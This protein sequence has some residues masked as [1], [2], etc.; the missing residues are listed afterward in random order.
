MQIYGEEH[1]RWGNTLKDPRVGSVW[2]GVCFPMCDVSSVTPCGTADWVRG[3]EEGDKVGE[4]NRSRLVVGELWDM[5]HTIFDFEWD[6][7]KPMDCLITDVLWL[8]W[9]VLERA[10]WRS[11]ETGWKE[12]RELVRSVIQWNRWTTTVMQIRILILKVVKSGQI[13][14][15][16]QMW[17]WKD[18]W[19]LVH[20][21]QEREVENDCWGVGG[22][23]CHYR[24]RA[25]QTRSGRA[26]SGALEEK[27]KTVFQVWLTGISVKSR[28]PAF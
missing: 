27:S 21:I 23:A 13:W 24:E 22:W 18:W 11:L 6:R 5:W 8:I 15:A 7:G 4:V 16:F 1:S 19:W 14:Q 3:T 12:S 10:T 2:T 26:S 17:R 9:F 25:S 28:V 20:G